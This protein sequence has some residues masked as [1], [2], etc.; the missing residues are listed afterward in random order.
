[1]LH[2]GAEKKTGNF[3]LIGV[4]PLCLWFL[5]LWLMLCIFVF[6]AE[7]DAGLGNKRFLDEGRRSA[8]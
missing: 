3:I 1:M 7:S 6:Q 8:V 2:F 4:W 5:L